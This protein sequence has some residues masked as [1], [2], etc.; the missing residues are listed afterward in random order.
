[1]VNVFRNGTPE[2]YIR[3]VIA[4]DK[5]CKGEGI[6]KEAKQKYVVAR[7]ILQTLCT[8]LEVIIRI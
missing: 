1:V 5:V 2:E 4:I 6:D 8:M 3:A 7:R